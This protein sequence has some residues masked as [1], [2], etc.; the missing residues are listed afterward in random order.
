MTL[1]IKLDGNWSSF[2]LA[3][4]A[5]P[6]SVTDSAIAPSARMPPMPYY[7][8]M[9][10]SLK[11]SWWVDQC[12]EF[13]LLQMSLSFW[14]WGPR[15]PQKFRKSHWC[16]PFTATFSKRRKIGALWSERCDTD[17]WPARM[18]ALPHMI[19]RVSV[20]MTCFDAKTT[21]FCH[22]VTPKGVLRLAK[23][24]ASATHK[25]LWASS[26]E[27]LPKQKLMWQASLQLETYQ[28]SHW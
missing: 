25:G 2:Q 14:C 7:T 27:H 22:N 21:S 18:Y 5:P 1:T 24:H 26:R 23:C 11:T 28:L 15:S 9:L 6:L 3:N 13:M 17:G 20:R 10:L 12:P 8:S 4:S 19:V 16:V